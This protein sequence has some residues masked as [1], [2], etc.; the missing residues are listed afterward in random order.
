[1]TDDP[2]TTDHRGRIYPCFAGAVL[3]IVVDGQDRA[4][5]MQRPG[6]EEWRCVAGMLER[7]EGIEHASLRE[8]HEEA[9]PGVTGDYLGVVHADVVEQTPPMATVVSVVSLYRMTGGTVVPGDDMA[10]SRIRWI[11]LDD[12]ASGLEMVPVPRGGPAL[13]GRVRNLLDSLGPG[14]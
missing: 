12:L 3:V 13:W 8:L 9:G 2:T 11:R 10:G 6:S 14:R 5:F 1:M 4:L 7:D